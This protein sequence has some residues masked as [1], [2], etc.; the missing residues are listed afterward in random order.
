M[1]LIANLSNIRVK[2]LP[3]LIYALLTEAYNYCSC[4]KIR[5]PECIGIYRFD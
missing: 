3:I 4:N 1:K 2:N 5:Q